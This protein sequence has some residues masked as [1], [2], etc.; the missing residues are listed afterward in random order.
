MDLPPLEDQK[1]I[2]QDPKYG[3]VQSQEFVEEF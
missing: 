3:I 2:I 1:D